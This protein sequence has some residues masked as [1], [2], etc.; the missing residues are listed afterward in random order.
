MGYISRNG[1]T[2]L[3]EEWYQ[4]TSSGSDQ[5]PV[6]RRWPMPFKMSFFYFHLVTF[7]EGDTVPLNALFDEF[8][9]EKGTNSLK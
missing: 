1:D 2:A 4:Q 5:W 3:S 9:V 8:I 7:C 6:K